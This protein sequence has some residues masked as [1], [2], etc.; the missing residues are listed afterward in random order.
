MRVLIIDSLLS[1]TPGTRATG[2]WMWP[3]VVGCGH[4]IT[5]SRKANIIIT[6]DIKK[7]YTK[8]SSMNTHCILYM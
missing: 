2:G 5:I 7:C 3:L 1:V 4:Y 8:R 6:S